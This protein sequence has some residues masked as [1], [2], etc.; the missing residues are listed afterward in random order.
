MWGSC[1]RE[2]E[3]RGGIRTAPCGRPS[4]IVVLGEEAEPTQAI[5]LQFSIKDF[6]KDTS[7]G[8]NPRLASLDKRIWWFTL[9]YAPLK[10]WL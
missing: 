3:R 7:L 1:T 5:K 2:I 4:V 8:S 10:A 9:S 6:I